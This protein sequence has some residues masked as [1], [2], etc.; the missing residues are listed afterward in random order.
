M[1]EIDGKAKIIGTILRTGALGLLIYAVI[2]S[3]R[4]TGLIHGPGLGFVLLAGAALSL[5]GFSASEIVNAFK[6]PGGGPGRIADLETS[7]YFWEAAAR[8]MYMFGILGTT[9][10][11]IVGLGSSEGGISGISLRMIS[12]FQSTLYGMI[13]GVICYVPAMKLS[14]RLDRSEGDAKGD[15]S[16][17]LF[18]PPDTRLRFENVLGYGLVL[19]ILGWA[20]VSPISSTAPEA[21]LQPVKVFLHWPSLLVVLGGT[22]VLLLFMGRDAIGRSLPLA[23]AFTGLIGA[24]TGLIQTMLAVAGRSIE[25]VAAAMVFLLSCCFLA[26]TGMM[27]LGAP[28]EDRALKYRNAPSRMMSGRIAWLLFPLLTLVFLLVTFVLVITPIKK[29]G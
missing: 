19:V 10:S 26:L 5:T 7:R 6:H 14:G 3:G 1:T 11:F 28:L 29:V 25:E 9:I 16:A 12:A 24:I 2:A 27:I 8:N 18:R 23:F 20:M 15:E 13:L 21:P 4:F 17:P 22:V